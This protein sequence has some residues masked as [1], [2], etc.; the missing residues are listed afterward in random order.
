VG[1]DRL[2]PTSTSLD[3][4]FQADLLD[5]YALQAALEGVGAILHL[6]AA[7]GD[8]GRRGIAVLQGHVEPTRALIHAGHRAGVKTWVLY[9]TVATLGPSDEPL[10]ER[11]PF[12]P[13]IPYGASKAEAERLF[14]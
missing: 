11:A 8:W 13:A 4:S 9:S 1:F 14:K 10:D 12:S 2:P 5:D 6:A 7:K 3:E